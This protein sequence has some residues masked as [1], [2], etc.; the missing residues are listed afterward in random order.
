MFSEF[1]GWMPYVVPFYI[2][3]M[4]IGLGIAAY[5]IIA[6][7]QYGKVKKVPLAEDLKNVE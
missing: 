5:G 7:L 3:P 6:F 2:Y 4:I 1:A